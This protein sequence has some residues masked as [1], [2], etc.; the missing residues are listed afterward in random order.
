MCVYIGW[1]VDVW[2]C[3]EVCGDVCVCSGGVGDT[4]FKNVTSNHMQSIFICKYQSSCI[5]SIRIT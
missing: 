3:L 2:R 5:W 1:G 4:L